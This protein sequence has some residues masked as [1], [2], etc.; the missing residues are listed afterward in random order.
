LENV[1]EGEEKRRETLCC[2]FFRRRKEVLR[3][4]IGWALKMN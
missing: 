4:D 3:C 1:D 2:T